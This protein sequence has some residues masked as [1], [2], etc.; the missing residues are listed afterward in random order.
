MPPDCYT[1]TRTLRDSRP[2]GLRSKAD[3]PLHA[4]LKNAEIAF[5]RVALDHWHF[6]IDIL[7]GTVVSCAMR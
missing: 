7:T 3:K 6:I 1:G 4:T 5:T 2:N